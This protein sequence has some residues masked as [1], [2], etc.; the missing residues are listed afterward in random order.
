MSLRHEELH[1]RVAHHRYHAVVVHIVSRCLLGHEELER[2]A[3][4]VSGRA[5]LCLRGRRL[6]VVAVDVYVLL[7]NPAGFG[8]GL[9]VVPPYIG[10][11]QVTGSHENL[12]FEP[13]E[14]WN[15]LDVV[16]VWVGDDDQIKLLNT[17]NSSGGA[18]VD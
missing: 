15:V 11:G 3:A 14:V 13:S 7:D 18:P 17:P 5:W 8:R 2:H 10:F 12:G 6:V 16:Q 1:T 4:E 9:P